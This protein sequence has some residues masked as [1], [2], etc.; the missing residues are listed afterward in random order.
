MQ[1][2]QRDMAMLFTGVH[3]TLLGVM[4]VWHRRL[5][6]EEERARTWAREYQAEADR[7]VEEATE[8]ASSQIDEVVRKSQVDLQEVIAAGTEA[9]AAQENMIAGVRDRIT[10]ERAR[11]DDEAREQDVLT[12]FYMESTL[13]LIEVRSGELPME[14]ALEI[15]EQLHASV[16]VRIDAKGK[17]GHRLPGAEIHYL[18]TRRLMGVDD[19]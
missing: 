12:E 19:D 11:F 10:A 18:R 4:A 1:R 3:L 7:Q 8:W 13:L 6:Q 17:Y 15:L 16:T 9:R 5:K 2:K 14:R